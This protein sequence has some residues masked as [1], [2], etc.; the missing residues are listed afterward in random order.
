M[1]KA[2]NTREEVLQSSDLTN[3]GAYIARLIMTNDDVIFVNL[4]NL[5]GQL[6]Y[7]VDNL[8]GIPRIELTS[9]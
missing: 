1:N 3:Q 4:C 8:K 7:D 5:L 2:I 6:V 9:N